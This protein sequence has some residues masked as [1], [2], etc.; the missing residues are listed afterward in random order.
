MEVQHFFDPATSTL[1]YVVHEG[2]TGVVIDPVLDYDPKSART[3]TRSAEILA[4]YIDDRR[5]SMP[6][7][8]DTHAHADHLTAMPYFK[9]RY[10]A[11]TVTGSRVGD[12]QRAF[13]GIYNLGADFPMDGRQFDLL[14]DEAQ[15][16]EIGSFIVRAM[17][18]P[19][20]TPTHM[21]WQIGDALFV[22][23]TLFMPD[24]GTARCDFPGGSAEQIFDSIQ[25][26]YALPDHTRLFM[27]HD[28]QPGDRELRFVTTV[29]DQKRANIQLRQ[30]TTKQEF[31]RARKERDSRLEM[32]TL[33]LPAVQVNIRAGA[34]P[35]LEENGTAYLKI[36]LNLF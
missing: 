14:L 13:R 18:T 10:G 22:G 8:I 4:S 29:A 35:E 33:I 6:Y 16:L 27:C 12:V 5:L 24:Y 20:H 11:R 19:G 7:V 30:E 15:E 31:V 2:T 1:S 28:Y 32:P 25:R 17:H 34:L 23:D 36:P 26:I 3:S 21:S 9:K